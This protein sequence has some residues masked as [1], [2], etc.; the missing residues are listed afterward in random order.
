M[1]R[2]LPDLAL[3]WARP[4]VQLGLFGFCLLVSAAVSGLA[5]GGQLTE[6]LETLDR[7][8][9]ARPADPL[10]E[11]P[12][13]SLLSCRYGFTFPSFFLFTLTMIPAAILGWNNYAS[14]RRGSRMWY[15]FRRLPDR[16][17]VHRRCLAVPV[18]VLLAA[19][20]LCLALTGIYFLIYCHALPDACRPAGGGPWDRGDLLGV[21]W[22]F[23]R[24][25]G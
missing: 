4:A 15:T 3:P 12:F 5:F 10:P 22:L 23:E 25:Y 1:K 7:I 19:A 20:A 14:L 6:T 9:A 16:W 24:G 13:R 18:L 17:E 21:F 11:I 2:R 8:A